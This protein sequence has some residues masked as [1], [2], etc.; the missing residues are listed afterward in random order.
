MEGGGPNFSNS[1][2]QGEGGRGGGGDFFFV[3]C[4]LEVGA[5]FFLPI[6]FAE[7]PPH[8]PPSIN[9]ERSLKVDVLRYFSRL[10]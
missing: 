9:N 6:D 2:M 10:W 1:V 7:P 8:P 5:L 3:P 4:I